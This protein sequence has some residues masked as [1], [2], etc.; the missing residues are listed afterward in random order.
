MAGGSL[1][2]LS[3]LYY[4]L[5]TGCADCIPVLLSSPRLSDQTVKTKTAITSKMKTKTN[6]IQQKQKQQQKQNKLHKQTKAHRFAV[7]CPVGNRYMF[8][9]KP[10]NY[11]ICT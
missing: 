10:L 7:F 2:F 4:S 6:Q 5:C 3:S 8:F 9:S 1:L 11:R